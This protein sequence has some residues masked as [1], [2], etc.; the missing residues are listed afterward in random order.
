[1]RSRACASAILMRRRW[2]QRV[3]ARIPRTRTPRGTPTPRPIFAP[4]E[5]LEDVS[6]VA[7]KDE[8][9]VDAVEDGVC[10]GE[11]IEVEVDDTEVADA[12]ADVMLEAVLM[13]LP[14]E[15]GRLATVAPVL[16]K[17]TPFP[18]PQHWTSLL[19]Q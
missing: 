11:L 14:V 10:K 7:G 3:L 15:L 8:A 5:R 1:M 13:I 19:Q 6:L 17:K 2:Y 18:R 16:S 12:E 4:V 9:V